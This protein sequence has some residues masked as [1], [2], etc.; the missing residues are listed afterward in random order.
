MIELSE[1]RMWEILCGICGNDI[2][3]HG[4]AIEAIKQALAEQRELNGWVSVETKPEP[5]KDVLLYYKNLHDEGRTVKAFYVPAFHIEACGEED[6]LECDY[7]EAA[8]QY[9]IPAGWYECVDNWDEFSFLLIT[10]ATLIA[11]QPL[12]QP[13]KEPS[14]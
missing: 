12:P 8:D 9:Y 10:G 13:P 7:D 11:W 3:Q 2:L 6:D 14:E 5:G 1:N 4:H